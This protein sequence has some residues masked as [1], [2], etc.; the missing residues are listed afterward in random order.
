LGWIER[1]RFSPSPVVL[2]AIYRAFLVYGACRVFAWSLWA[3][4]L[5]PERDVQ[6]VDLSWSGP[7]WVEAISFPAASWSQFA[8]TTVI[9]LTGL[10]AAL[11]VIWH[12][13]GR[14]LWARAA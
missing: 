1:R 10:T 9:G 11:V 3:R 4:F 5:N 2:R 7:A 13:I 8:R 12:S 6:V 14:P